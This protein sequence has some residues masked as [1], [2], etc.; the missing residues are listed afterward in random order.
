MIYYIHL[1]YLT[2]QKINFFASVT[3]TNR[4]CS[5]NLVCPFLKYKSVFAYLSSAVDAFKFFSFTLLSNR[6]D[7]RPIWLIEN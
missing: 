3:V 5:Q 6:D 2:L 4:N 1:I 7:T